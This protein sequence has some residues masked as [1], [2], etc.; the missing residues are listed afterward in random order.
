MP[1]AQSNG[2][3]LEYETFGAKTDP[4][5]LLVMGF[6]MQM[7]GWDEKFCGMIASH[8]Y[9]VVRFDNRDV[10]L[11][12]K[13]DA[14]GLP[15]IPAIM[16][17]DHSTVPYSLEDMARDSVG[18]LDVLGIER[19]HIVGASMG[20]MIAQLIALEH[21]ER[22]LS[23][24]SI[25]STT[26]DR[27][28]GQAAPEALA[29]L[30]VPPPTERDAYVARAV[31]VS[32][33]LGSRSLPTDPDVVR[34]R[35]GRAFDRAF[36]PAGGA[37]QFAAILGA[38]DRT[39]RLRGVKVPTLVVHGDEDRLIAPDGGEATARAIPNAR[40]EVLKGMGHDFPREL[41]GPL[42]EMLVANFQRA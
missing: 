11:S 32:S 37:R 41:W 35:A 14:H 16:G 18:L 1:R 5:V 12:T 13:M 3:E 27:S 2:I 20:G 24:T 7:H 15:K 33:V 19:A 10:G 40:H 25:M 28:V 23:L 42:V 9:H 39:E 34:A 38:A 30:F 29:V 6:T 8:G 26:G 4:T 36:H 17:G 31:E 22:V 21:P